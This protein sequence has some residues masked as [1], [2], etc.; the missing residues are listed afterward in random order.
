MRNNAL[1]F[2]FISV[3]D[4]KWVIKTLL[5]WD[6]LASIV[7]TDFI[8]NPG[9]H[10]PFMQSLV[11]EGLVDQIFPGAHLFQINDFEDIFIN[12]IEQKLRQRRKGRLF[13]LITQGKIYSKRVP[14]HIEK[15]GNL[16]PWLEQNNLARKMDYSW[17]E[18]E[19]WVAAPFMAYLANVLGSLEE[20]NAAPVTD[21]VN[22]SRYYQ[23][24][25][26]G[27]QNQ[28]AIP[29]EYI[30]DHLLPV[31]DGDVSLDSLVRFKQD[32]GHLLPQLRN[33]IE[34]Y[35]VELATITNDEERRG[36]AD[37][38]ILDCKEDIEEIKESMSLSWGKIVLSS[39][40]PLLGAGGA[41]YV[42]DPH[43]NAIAAS[44]AGLS[45][46]AASYQA[47]SNVQ[48]PNNLETKPLAYLAF[49]E[50]Q[51]QSA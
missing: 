32:Y 24:F 35:S 7:P 27:R 15:M 34:T 9:L 13:Q 39:L 21:S 30:L 28:S 1:Y 23:V 20:V 5:Y 33:K 31:P 49:A 38:I 40:I 26:K 22:L 18:V 14:V 37:T 48:M 2:P 19:D 8:D 44:A 29:R 42:T 12:Y 11:T 25:S 51:W 16:A 41:M 36:R 47:I 6:R 45:F 4:S 3:P 17:Y 10:S 46:L 43:Q 50:K